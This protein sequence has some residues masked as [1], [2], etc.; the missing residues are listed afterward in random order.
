[1]PPTAGG[2]P[3]HPRK[4]I[5][6]HLI[7]WQDALNSL[8]TMPGGRDVSDLDVSDIM[9]SYDTDGNGVLDSTEF[10]PFL[11]DLVMRQA[12]AGSN[13]DRTRHE[14]G[15]NAARTVSARGDTPSRK[16]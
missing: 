7:L 8:G 16:M 11:R 2:I 12:S 14:R 15:T 13:A 4:L 5:S 9:R 10:R 3:S 1:M 6:S